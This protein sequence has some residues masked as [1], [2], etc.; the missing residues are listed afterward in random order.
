MESN[1]RRVA[2]A[3]TLLAF[4]VAIVLLTQFTLS[5]WA[6]S[7]SVH[8]EIQHGLIFLSGIGVG[9][10]GLALYRLGRARPPG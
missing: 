4:S 10:S 7:N 9:A 8:H 5:S 2:A 1:R 6:E 3:F